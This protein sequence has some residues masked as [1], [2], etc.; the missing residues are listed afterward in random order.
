MQQSGF[1]M[2]F[3]LFAAQH[4]AHFANCT[5][6]FSSGQPLAQLPKDASTPW[7]LKHQV[8]WNGP[9]A[10]FGCLLDFR[11]PDCKQMFPQGKFESRTKP[12][13]FLGV[14]LQPGHIY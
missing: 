2:K 5:I 11:V 7:K 3:W 13:L 6:P 4:F 8:D 10:P 14:H 12:G 1:P 9:S